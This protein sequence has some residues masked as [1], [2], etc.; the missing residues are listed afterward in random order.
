[1]TKVRLL[2]LGGKPPKNTKVL[3]MVELIRPFV[4]ILKG[5]LVESLNFI[6]VVIGPRQV[7]KTTGVKAVIADWKG[8][9]HFV[10]ADSPSPPGHDWLNLQFDLAEQ[11]GPGALLVIDEVQKVT[12]WSEVIKFRYDKIRSQRALRIVLL[13]SA[14]LS[15]Q[16]GLTESLAGRFELL[17]ARHWSYAECKTAFGW[18]FARYLAY[19][20]Y[21]APAELVNSIDRWRSFMRDSIIEPVVGR[22]LQGVV[23]IRKPALFR[24]SFEV[25][26]SC[27]SHVLSLQKFLGQ[28]QEGGNVSTIKYY[29]ELLEAAFLLKALPKYSR[30]FIS[31]RSSSPKIIPLAPALIHAFNSP[32][33]L[34][35]DPSWR[36]HVFEA[37]IGAH[38]ATLPGELTYWSH[39][40][41]E[42]D[43]IREHDGHT[44]AYEVKSGRTDR[45]SGLYRF[46]QIY[47]E[48]QLEVIDWE[49]GERMLL[50]ASAA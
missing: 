47:P 14:S 39:G 41:Y 48:A 46:K 13:G 45:I 17:H 37:A 30:G 36:G 20:G 42:V 34:E 31:S 33:K 21:P 1:M 26:M 24:R 29:L 3:Y 15:L 6:Q 7:G 8:P 4:S 28:L 49:R 2:K 40:K 50:E 19:G 18:S 32:D 27:P 12:G 5:R 22:D 9:T 16:R 44:T 23:L 10:S 11:L 35:M 43:F 38:L 25:A